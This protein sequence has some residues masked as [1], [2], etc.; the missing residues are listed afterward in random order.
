MYIILN[1]KYRQSLQVLNKVLTKQGDQFKWHLLHGFVEKLNSLLS[2]D[3]MN[4]ADFNFIN[5]S[6]KETKVALKTMPCFTF[7]V[8]SF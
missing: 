1:G 4:M 8:F 6:G 2:A 7:C 5:T 3:C